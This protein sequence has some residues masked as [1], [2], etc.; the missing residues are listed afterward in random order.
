MQLQCQAVQ[1]ITSQ[2]TSE[3][4]SQ[5]QEQRNHPIKYRAQPLHTKVESRS[6]SEFYEKQNHD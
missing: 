3:A 2:Q 4:E 5:R 1:E 6:V